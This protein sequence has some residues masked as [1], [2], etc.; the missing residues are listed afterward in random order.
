LN[1]LIIQG[2]FSRCDAAQKAL[3]TYR[4]ESD[5]VAMFLEDEGYGQSKDFSVVKTIYRSYRDYCNDNGCKPLGRNK[6]T[7]RLEAND[8]VIDRLSVGLVAYIQQ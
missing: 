6:F 5:S 1:R 4:K 2:K 7:K 3:E 8:V